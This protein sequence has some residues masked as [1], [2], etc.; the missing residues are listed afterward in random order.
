MATD[1]LA[2]LD[3]LAREVQAAGIR[4][5]TGDVIVDDRL[6]APAQ[7]TGS[8]PRQVSPIV[9][10]DNVIDVLAAARRQGGRAGAGHLSAGDPVRD[11]GRPGRDG[12]G[13]RW[14]PRSW[15]SRS[16]RG[17]SRFAASCRSATPASSRSTRSMSRRRLPARS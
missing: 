8:G 2:G 10:N 16:A 12:R 15:S 6:F 14:R 9:I 3:H 7:A 4:E 11:D 17:G 5:I 13:R 1:P